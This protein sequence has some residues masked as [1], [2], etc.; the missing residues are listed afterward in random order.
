MGTINRFEEA[1]RFLQSELG[2]EL[3]MHQLRILLMV[4]IGGSE[5]V[6]H[7]DIER[8]LGISHASVSRN[9]Q[10]LGLRG[11]TEKGKK[12]MVGHGLTESKPDLWE[13]KKLAATL[14][15]KG[16]KLVKKLT[17]I[18]DGDDADQEEAQP[19]LWDDKGRGFAERGLLI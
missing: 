18:L 12:K 9:M 8:A 19:G 15:P 3:Q 17:R 13:P 4:T 2:S 16:Q 6:K 7:N 14:T 11:V 5:G 10:M 1:I